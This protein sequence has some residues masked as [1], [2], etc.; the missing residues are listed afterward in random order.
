MTS[1][2]SSYSFDIAIIP[3]VV[4]LTNAINAEETVSN[5]LSRQTTDAILNEVDQFFFN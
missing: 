4:I 5:A 1:F 3:N 2:V